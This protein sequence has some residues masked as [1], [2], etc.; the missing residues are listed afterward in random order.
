VRTVAHGGTVRRQVVA[1][2]AHIKTLVRLSENPVPLVLDRTCRVVAQEKPVGPKPVRESV[3]AVLNRAE[4]TIKWAERE[5]RFL[6]PK[7][8]EHPRRTP[9]V[10]KRTPRA[11]LA[12]A[13]NLRIGACGAFRC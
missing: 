12:V 8:S 1:A 7:A 5:L 2:P 3:W 13:A 6:A 9:M 4:R 11:R 10:W